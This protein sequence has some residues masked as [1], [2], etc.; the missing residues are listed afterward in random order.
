MPDFIIAARS[1][2]CEHDEQRRFDVSYNKSGF[3]EFLRDCLRKLSNNPKIFVMDSV[4]FHHLT[5]IR[6]VV[7]SQG[8]QIFFITPYSPDL[9]PIQLLFSKWKSITESGMSIFDGNTLT[10]RL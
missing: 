5:E 6:K 7:D 9:N 2:C 4:R 3:C 1:V 8:R 10:D